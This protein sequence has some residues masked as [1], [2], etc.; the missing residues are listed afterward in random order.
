MKKVLIV[1]DEM[2]IALTLEQMIKNMRHEVV[3]KVASGKQAVEKALQLKPDI[4]L[5]DIRLK[6]KMDGIDT[7]KKIQHKKAD[8]PVIYVT[9]SSN[10][11]YIERIKATKYI[12]FIRKPITQHQLMQSFKKA[13]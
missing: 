8:I 13:S 6:G 12:D 3:S 4:I 1:E 5:M 9:G 7:I 2:I 10:S 11:R